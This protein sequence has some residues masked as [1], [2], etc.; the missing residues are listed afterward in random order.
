MI[1][2]DINSRASE[3]KSVIGRRECIRRLNAALCGRANVVFVIRVTDFCD[4]LFSGRRWF[5]GRAESHVG[6]VLCAASVGRS[7]PSIVNHPAIAV[8]FLRTIGEGTTLESASH[9][10]TSIIRSL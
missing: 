7:N 3:S 10:G 2:G 8:N 9:D 5:H 1:S 6:L 4:D